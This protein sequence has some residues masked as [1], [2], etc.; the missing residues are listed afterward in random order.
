MY[1]GMEDPEALLEFGVLVM[2][3]LFGLNPYRV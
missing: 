1:G 2:K 3:R